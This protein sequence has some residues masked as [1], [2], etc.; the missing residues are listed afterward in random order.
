MS[1]FRLRVLSKTLID[2]CTQR[3]RACGRLGEPAERAFGPIEHC[4]V[5]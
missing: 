1:L 5:Q 4:I 2:P 3:V